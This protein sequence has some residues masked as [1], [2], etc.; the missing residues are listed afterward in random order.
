MRPILFLSSLLALVLPT[1]SKSQDSITRTLP[2]VVLTA[3]GV[4]QSVAQTGRN[5][6]VIPGSLLGRSPAYS[7]DDLLRFIPGLEIQQ[8]GPQG[9]QG[10]LLIR[11]GTFQQVLVLVDGIRLND[12]L[13]GHFSG[14]IPVDPLEIDRIEVLKGPASAIWGSE[15]V[16][17]VI[18]IFTK[19]FAKLVDQAKPSIQL[20]A[21]VGEYNMINGQ[22]R[23][24]VQKNKHRLSFSG[25][26]RNSDGAPQRGTRGYFNLHTAQAAWQQDLSHGWNLRL[27]T[28]LDRRKFGAQNFYTGFISDTASESVNTWWSHVQLTK[29]MRQGQLRLDV[30]HKQLFDEYRFRPVSIPNQNNI[31]FTQFQAIYQS[32]NKE[33]CQYQ[34]GLQGYQRQIRSNDR[35]N[36][37]I[38]QGA[39]FSQVRISPTPQINL[40]AGLRLVWDELYGTIL[41][42]QLS[43]SFTQKNHDWRI[44]AGRSFRDADFTERYNNYNKPLVTSGRIGNPYLRPEDAWQ[45]EVGYDWRTSAKFTLH[46]SLFYRDQRN[47]IDW[48]T[49]PYV[50]MPRTIN[51]SPTGTYGLAKNVERVRTQGLEIDLQY[52]SKIG[53]GQIQTHAG[54]LLLNNRTSAGAAG[55]YLNS[56]ARFLTNALLL[57]QIKNWEMS[58]GGLYKLRNRQTSNSLNSALTPSYVLI[59]SK[60]QFGW[61]DRTYSLYLQTDNLLNTRY[62]DLLGAPMPGRWLSGGFRV[63]L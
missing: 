10:D 54:L 50:Q 52:R 41:L 29:T 36:H 58:V 59:H 63:I 3:N 26:T 6:W 57:Y 61:K 48:I 30:S 23:L 27:R 53:S 12:P 47:L 51:L 20:G 42:P 43:N 8:R 45:A 9:T 60:I 39:L 7:I 56:H 25:N 40:N 18:Q 4:T 34:F 44:S 24:F 49:T 55:F 33:K 19:T 13:T 37:Q 62:S 17:G 28:S 11:G 5:I 35:G 46:S 32:G 21:A 15:A 22:A 1:L 16:G 38:E 2:E 31:D 14:Y